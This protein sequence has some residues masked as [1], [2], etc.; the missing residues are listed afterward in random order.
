MED[1]LAL[2]PHLVN[3]SLSATYKT[4]PLHRTASNGNLEIVSLLVEKY[5]A[6]VDLQTSTGETALIGATKR[7]RLEVVKY[8]LSKNSDLKVE[9]KSG[10]NALD[11]AVLQGLYPLALELYQSCEELIK[12]AEEYESLGRK[13]KY[14]YVNYSLFLDTLSK[15]IHPENAP[16]FLTKTHKR[17]EDPVVDPR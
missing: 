9:S 7:N 10:L 17:L 8:L 16:N 15:K 4:T 3:E 1:L 13:Y 14:R 11:Y 2:K 12:P 6:N 5:S